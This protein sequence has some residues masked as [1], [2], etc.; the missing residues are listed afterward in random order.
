MASFSILDTLTNLLPAS[1]F[2]RSSGSVVGVDVGSS[3]VKVVQLKKKGGKVVLETYG[4]LSL[5]P[6]AGTEAGRG[7]N[8]SADKLATAVEDLFREA[9]VTTRDGGIAMPLSSS[10]ISL[11]SMPAL[12]ESKM[13]E[14]GIAMPPSRVEIGRAH[15]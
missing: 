13:E 2:S 11:V 8:L 9:N 6:Y 10:L 15:V 14:S 4:S 1:L 5:G 3:A 7:T 12:E